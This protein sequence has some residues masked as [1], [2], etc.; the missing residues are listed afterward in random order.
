[1]GLSCSKCAVVVFTG[2][3]SGNGGS[4]N[5]GANKPG[6]ADRKSALSANNKKTKNK[7]MQCSRQDSPDPVV[8]DLTRRSVAFS[9]Q[10]ERDISKAGAS[11]DAQVLDTD[12]NPANVVLKPVAAAAAAQVYPG[13]HHLLYKQQ[14]GN[15][16]S[17]A[18]VI[19]YNSNNKSKN[20]KTTDRDAAVVTATATAASAS[21]ATGTTTTESKRPMKD[22]TAAAA[23]TTAAAPK[24]L[25][26]IKGKSNKAKSTL[27]TQTR[28]D[29]PTRVV[30]RRHSPRHYEEGMS[31]THI[32]TIRYPANIPLDSKGREL[33][34]QAQEQCPT[35]KA[36]AAV[37]QTPAASNQDPSTAT[38]LSPLPAENTTPA[39]PTTPVV[40]TADSVKLGVGSKSAQTMTPSAQVEASGEL[41]VDQLFRPSAMAQEPT[42]SSTCRTV[43]RRVSLYRI[44]CT[45]SH[46]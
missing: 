16:N 44:V 1:M 10:R 19:N 13:Q 23:K 41:N 43:Y 26:H 24:K 17:H 22:S 11:K 29:F 38:T 8:Y 33:P 20:K 35:S 6:R 42:Q 45:Y 37:K 39:R 25:S 34:A 4:G 28:S 27:Y 18:A 2:E 46:S 12:I 36:T 5:G 40:P 9:Q 30:V 7:A 14:K 31:G 32:Y 3:S 21:A 15:Q